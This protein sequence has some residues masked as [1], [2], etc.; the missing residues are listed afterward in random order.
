[1]EIMAGKPGPLG[2]AALDAALNALLAEYPTAFVAAINADGVFVPMPASLPLTGQ[3]VLHARSVLDL[4][5]SEDRERVISTWERARETGGATAQVRLALDPGRPAVI[6]YV[7]ARARHG[8]YVGMVVGADAAAL[9]R[10]PE[11]GPT[12]PRM[13]RV[14]KNEVAVF[15]E[16][17]EATTK[18]LGWTAADMVGL[19]SL[20]FIHPEDYDRAIESWM[21]MLSEPG[22][23]Q[24]PVRLRHRRSDGSW[25]WFEV[26]NHNQLADPDRG[27]VLAEMIDISDEMAAH[28]TVRAREH[29]LH[30]LAEALPIG[31]FQVLPDRRIVYA[32]DRLS[33]I[34]GLG[35]AATVD[36][37]LASVAREDLP[38]LLAA[39]DAALDNGIDGD[40]EVR[41]QPGEGPRARLCMLRLRVL[42]DPGGAVTGAVVSVEDVT[43]SARLRA[44]LERRATH[45]VLTRVMNRS[46]AMDV[47]EA[48]L[49]CKAAG[50]A[51]IFVDIDRFKSVNDRL[52]HMAGDELLR[53][54]A[55]RL[56]LTVRAGDALGRIGGDEFLVVCPG[57]V[58][59]EP[60]LR[61]A[62][63]IA[64][65]VNRPACLAGVTLDLQV[66]IGVAHAG[67]RAIGADALVRRADT[68]MY[69]SK[70][71]GLGRP[72][73]YSSALL[74]SAPIDVNGGRRP[75]KVSVAAP[76]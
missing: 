56:A 36:A 4:V 13:A 43:E 50:T 37:Q 54:V 58:G 7:D 32:N 52:G 70:R 6:H 61:V 31:V 14:C 26:T 5:I 63:R 23:V 27:Y 11:I 22:T 30:R 9:T 19:R 49:A 67:R 17:D 73:A 60:A 45:D 48:A 15:L 12:P 33:G 46:A 55:D 25:T 41:V 66:S 10:L 75:E 42:T 65:A 68:A 53:I 21:Q 71:R 1:M 44:E 57:V 64:R 51:V 18:I 62:D 69:A 40:L 47:L 74:R 2:P 35:P 24:P 29:L 34:L 39:L 59:D 20:D 28:E 3:Q 16:V 72:V 76:P 38:I 8:V